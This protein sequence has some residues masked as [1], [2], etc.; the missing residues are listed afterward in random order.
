MIVLPTLDAA[1]GFL[2]ACDEPVV[3]WRLIRLAGDG[4]EAPARRR[5]ATAPVVKAAISRQRVDGSWG[6]HERAGNRVLP[7]LW[8]M[9]TLTELGL[10][11]TDASWEAAGAFLA[12]HATCEGIFSLS[13]ERDGVLSCYVGAAALMFMDGGRSDLAERQIEWIRAHQ[14]V[15]VSGDDRRTKEPA[16]WSS[17]LSTKYG[18]CMAG[19]SCLVGLL[20][21]G[22]ALA[23]WGSEE[24]AGLVS[25]IR[26]VFLERRA[27]YRSGGEVL[28]LAVDPS[29]SE[30]WLVPTFPLDW[31]I[32]IVEL[33]GFLAGA[34]SDPR[35]QPA[36]DRISETQLPDGAWPL[37]RAFR[38]FRG[39]PAPNPNRPSPI[40][41]MRVV[42]ALSPLL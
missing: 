11:G 27:M 31:R 1:L 38:P 24:D 17:H 3:S 41:T 32:D 28:P 42:E 10:H 26:E 39:L 40:A 21:T 25:A 37:L 34:G 6:D 22:R 7:T 33:V 4:D 18:G 12:E 35:L 29:K 20:R 2:R 5:A 23:A 19:T 14:E 36:I 15:K 9:K 8:H 13:G 16:P 30:S